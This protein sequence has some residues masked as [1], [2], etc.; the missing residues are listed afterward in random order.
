MLH[1]VEK[2]AMGISNYARA[3]EEREAANAA[4]GTPRRGERT[5]SSKVASRICQPTA[6]LHAEFPSPQTL[7]FCK[8][9]DPARANAPVPPFRSDKMGERPTFFFFFTLVTGPRRSLNLEL[10]DTRV[11]EP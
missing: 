2:K 7:S 10:I 1:V 4:A 3:R 6:F 11:Y 5:F 8:P 9:R